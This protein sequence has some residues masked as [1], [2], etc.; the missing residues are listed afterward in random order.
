[1]TAHARR[2]RRKGS[3][4]ASGRHRSRP[5][6]TPRA[7]V[8]STHPSHP[9]RPNPESPVLFVPRT[10][11]S[12]A[13]PRESQL[14]DQRVPAEDPSAGQDTQ[15]KALL[16]FLWRV[17]KDEDSQDGFCRLIRN[18][19]GPLAIVLYFTMPAALLL[20]AI[21]AGGTITLIAIVTSFMRWLP[22]TRR[23]NVS[24]SRH[25]NASMTF[26]IS[27]V[28]RTIT[29]PSPAATSTQSDSNEAE[30]LRHASA[31][32]STSATLRLPPAPWKP[33]PS[34]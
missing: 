10:H 1:M 16:Y 12:L 11:E 14:S 26:A 28:S 8:G 15:L 23:R 20:R 27:R 30:D 3:V 18:V 2:T 33:P 13:T 4:T 6:A 25:E 7:S 5:S 29:R 19:M 9:S 31:E 22:R 24:Q 32:R 21:F 17:S 34:G